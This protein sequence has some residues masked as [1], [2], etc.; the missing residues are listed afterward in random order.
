[1]TGVERLEDKCLMVGTQVEKSSSE[2][3]GARK[4]PQ[5]KWVLRDEYEFAR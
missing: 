2:V 1:M 3:Q 5:K 4:V